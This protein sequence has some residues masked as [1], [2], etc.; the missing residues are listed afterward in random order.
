M[1]LRGKALPLLIAALLLAGPAVIVASGLSPSPL[2][3]TTTM[4]RAPQH[5]MSAAPGAVGVPE[6]ESGPALTSRPLGTRA[7]GTACVIVIPV[8]FTD[9]THA[10]AHTPGFFDSMINAPSGQSVN[11]FYRENSYGTFGFSGAVANWVRSTHTMAYYGQDGS[12]VDDATGPIYRL[13][14]E[15]VRLADP[16]VDFSTCDQNGDGV[17][18]HIVVVHAGGAQ[19]ASANTNLIWSHRWAVIDGNPA[20]PGDQQLTA[21]GRQ[22]YG[23]VMI[24]EDSPFG[25]LAHEFGHDLGLPDLYDTDGSSPGI[26]VWDVMASGSWNGNPRGTSPSDFSAWSKSKLGWVVPI[27]VTSPLLSHSVPQVENN[28]AVFRLTVKTAPGGDEYFLVENRE[29]SG[30]D[31]AQ[32]GSGLLIW[33]VDDSVPNNDNE[34]HRL[35]DLVESDEA[36]AG[37]SPSDAGDPWAASAAGWGPD[38]IPNSNGYGNI[39]TGWKVR[40]IS[41]AGSVMVADLSREVDDD[42][43][44]LK[45]LHPYAI[46][47]GQPVDVTVTLKNQGG[48]TQSTVAASL[49]VFLDSLSPASEIPVP[50]GTQVIPTFTATAFQNLTWQFTA[51]SQGRYILDAR[52]NLTGDEIP[53]N[54]ERLAH[55]TSRAFVDS[56]FD[57]VESGPMWTTPGQSGTDAY[58]WRIVDDSQSYGRSHSPTHAWRFGYVGGLPSLFAYH[59]LVSTTASVPQG[60]LYLVYYQTYDLSRTETPTQAETDHGYVDI[61]VDG[62]PWQQV[63]HYYGKNPSWQAVGLNLTSYLPPGVST[64]Q[65]RFNAT[66]NIMPNTG[67]WWVD[68]IM[69]TTTN[70]S[71]AVAVTPVVSDRTI[72]P[73]AEAVFTLKVSNIGDFDDE[74]RFAAVLPSGWT[75]VLVNS[76]SASAVTDARVRLASDAESTVQFRAQS[77]AGVLRGSVEQI[78]LTVS[79]TTDAN[80]RAVFVATARINDPLGLGGIQK[81]I[82]WLIVLGIALVVVIILVD[83][84]KSRRFRGQIR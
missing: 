31:A 29:Q 58:Q 84:A 34:A 17:V 10:G 32:P 12:G 55:V 63:A 62:G 11:A 44:V 1:T 59:T 46:L 52:V 81:Y 25:V 24:S 8:E 53:E 68:D 76:T 21:D 45:V 50:S 47:V 19:E 73:G 69:L 70:I 4:K 6:V 13:V 37:D 28:S 67:G 83:H 54:N 23:Y 74:F 14:A 80:Q 7:T 42:L 27:D 5:L 48:R 2:P 33:H 43:A 38:S 9:V 30:F 36:T 79:S 66:S 64:L 39:R 77:P 56:F 18:D 40:N 82:V 20:L 22:I 61:M 26:G 57:D 16:F 3:T 51:G 78:P 75:A 35:V 71:R 15:A 72:E 49:R 65:I 41:P 60:P